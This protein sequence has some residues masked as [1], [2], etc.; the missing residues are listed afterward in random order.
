LAQGYLIGKPSLSPE[1]QSEWYSV[2]K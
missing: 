2:A 1:V